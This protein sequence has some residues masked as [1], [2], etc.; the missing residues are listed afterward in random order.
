[1]GN[2]EPRTVE[3]PLTPKELASANKVR[4]DLVP[5]DALREVA[6]VLGSG[7]AKYTDRGWEQGVPWSRY[8]AAAQRHLTSW[9]QDHLDYDP[10]T[11]RATLAHAACCVLFLLAYQLRTPLPGNERGKDDRP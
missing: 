7:A 1:M 4:W 8:Y 6:E 11:G 2:V 5:W 3:E 9:F 10:E